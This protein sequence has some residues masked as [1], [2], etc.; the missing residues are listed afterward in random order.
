[1][2]KG[3]LKLSTL[4]FSSIL[5]LNSIVTPVLL[6]TKINVSDD[7]NHISRSRSS[8]L[9]PIENISEVFKNINLDDWNKSTIDFTD[10]KASVNIK[11]EDPYTKIKQVL[12]E[13]N[14]K[15]YISMPNN[16]K[17]KNDQEIMFGYRYP[18]C[19]YRKFFP[20][21]EF[22]PENAPT[23]IQIEHRIFGINDYK[24]DANYY[25][26]TNGNQTNG[27]FVTN[28]LDG[29][30]IAHPKTILQLV[31]Q[32]NNQLK[33]IWEDEKFSNKF[34]EL[35]KTNFK[36]LKNPHL[37]Y[38]ENGQDLYLW[39][40]QKGTSIERRDDP[41]ANSTVD[42]N[43]EIIHEGE[44]EGHKEFVKVAK[45]ASVEL[46]DITRGRDSYSTRIEMKDINGLGV[47]MTYK[48]SKTPSIKE[49]QDLVESN[50]KFED[51][52]AFYICLPG[53]ERIHP[54]Y[55]DRNI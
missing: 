35:I 43:N 6:A 3:F 20:T 13:A 5:L 25:K 16:I 34:K 10:Y 29:W 41:N 24:A 54:L 7:T 40:V 46:I 37:E 17:V 52:F 11:N 39:F 33:W 49:D 53:L 32:T 27:Y 21:D 2:K 47:D 42:Q 14:N 44:F 48:Y 55:N 26:T 50:Y 45:Y 15:D 12:D 23:V 36:D 18:T 19:D 51:G 38:E 22:A 1:M 8:N 4:G 30:N 9:I 31:T 28:D